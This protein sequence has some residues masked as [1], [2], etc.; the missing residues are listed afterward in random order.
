MIRITHNLGNLRIPHVFDIPEFGA[1][2]VFG[3]NATGKSTIV[4]AIQLAL[5]GE[6]QDIGM[7]KAA[8]S[9]NILNQMAGEDEESA[10]SI[11]TPEA[12]YKIL[13]FEDLQSALSGGGTTLARILLSISSHVG[14]PLAILDFAESEAKGLSEKLKAQDVLGIA[15]S[16]EDVRKNKEL[17][18][19]VREAKGN[20]LKAAVEAWNQDAYL[21]TMPLRL[22]RGGLEVRP[23][24]SGDNGPLCGV[25]KILVCCYLAKRLAV[26]TPEKLL[27]CVPDA[28]LSW[29]AFRTI[30]SAASVD[31][32]ALWIFQKACT[33]VELQFAP[34]LAQQSYIFLEGP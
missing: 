34:S 11:A 30:W 31:T 26:G 16:S 2:C 23:Q 33:E 25:E 18:A 19:K 6:V 24:G 20:V 22:T 3:D 14:V 21:Q 32:D 5:T 17:G 15:P 28:S 12:S 8:K 9:K 7:R 13:D 27:I 29:S 10:E 4:H 1:F